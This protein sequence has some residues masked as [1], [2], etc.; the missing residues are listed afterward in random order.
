MSTKQ[1]SNYEDLLT[2]T[3]ASGGH[4]L[5]PVSYGAELVTNGGFATDVSSWAGGGADQSSTAFDNGT[6]KV[7]GNTFEYQGITTEIGKVYAASVEITATSQ[8]SSLLRLGTTINGTDNFA[9]SGLAVGS[10][11][12]YFV[13]TATT[14]YVTLKTNYNVGDLTKSTNFDNISV[15][16]VTFDQPDGTLT[17]FEHPVNVPRVEW[18]S[19]GNRLGLLVEEARTNLIAYSE[20]FSDSYWSKLSAVIG[21][22][23]V[24]NPDGTSDGFLFRPTSTAPRILRQVSS[25]T[26]D[27]THSVYAK[28]GGKD[29]IQVGQYNGSTYEMVLVDLNNG[30]IVAS[31]GT[32]SVT[33]MPNGWYRI[34][35]TGDSTSTL[36]YLNISCGNVGDSYSA[37]AIS[38]TA[39]GTSGIYIYGAQVEAG[40]F[41]TSYIKTT[42]ATAT[43]SADVASIPVADFGFNQSEGTIAVTGQS[44][45]PGGDN[46]FFEMSVD[47]SNRLLSKCS[48]LQHLV[49]L[50]GGVTQATLD[51]GTITANTEAKVAAAFKNNDFAVA[52][53]GG[54]AAT[55]TSGTVELAV[56]ELRI[57]AN[58]QGSEILNGHIKSIQYYPRRLTNAQLQALTEPRSTPTLSLT[59]DGLESSY[60]ENYIHG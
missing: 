40:S 59:F 36:R 1:F 35:V 37:T 24:T 50:S 31:T 45:E 22:T 39:D 7:F 28:A 38:T 18:D 2:F 52:L 43:R 42:G 60:T 34:S 48:T 20:D 53:D 27:H 49:V 44:Y 25:T 9:S 21:S 58:R 5:R 4:A 10:Y 3:R 33:S 15:K 12:F 23:T 56:S 46:Y 17:L 6:I 14:T 47:G 13:A 32:A 16:E 11:T 55:D 29:L 19:A 30:D 41:P 8:D 54:S 51:A 26:A 57:G